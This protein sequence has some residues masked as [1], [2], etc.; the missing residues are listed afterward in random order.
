M[1]QITE[2]QRAI[3][4]I[5]K[6][7]SMIEKTGRNNSQGY[8]YVE[9]SEIVQRFHELFV[10]H[11]LILTSSVKN[12]VREQT[13]TK[14][15]SPRNNTVLTMQFTITSLKDGS[16]TTTDFPAEGTDSGDKGIPKALTM[17]EKY[18]LMKTFML[19]SG[20]D[21][22]ADE[23]QNEHRSLLRKAPTPVTE[24]KVA[25]PTPVEKPAPVAVT[26]T[27]E[28]KPEPAKKLDSPTS[29]LLR[30]GASTGTTKPT[31]TTQTAEEIINKYSVRGPTE[32]STK[33]NSASSLLRR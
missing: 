8:A 26:P 25:A 20:D 13:T 30:R 28:V 2:V 14:D 4:E 3:F 11:N 17:A 22:E 5:M 1:Q 10:K 19:A 27:P 21:A 15:G 23:D 6:E 9:S 16:S 32:V 7:A 33:N 18:F 29:S 12:I 24:T 31:T